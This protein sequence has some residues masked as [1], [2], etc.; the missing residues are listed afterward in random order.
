MSLSLS[1]EKRKQRYANC[2]REIS[3]RLNNISAMFRLVGPDVLVSGE[4]VTA[5]TGFCEA[6][7]PSYLN[8]PPFEGVYSKKLKITLH[9]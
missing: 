5:V 7:T 2:A 3:R 4:T 9:S 6:I 8:N 1:I